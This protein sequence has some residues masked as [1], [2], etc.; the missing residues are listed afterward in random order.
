MRDQIWIDHKQFEELADR[1]ENDLNGDV[2]KVFEDYLARVAEETGKRLHKGMSRKTK[3]KTE[4]KMRSHNRTGR[5]DSAI[6]NKG[7]QKWSGDFVTMDVG[8]NLLDGGIASIFLLYGTPKMEPDK[9]LY[10]AIFGAWAKRMQTKLGKEAFEKAM[11]R[12]LKK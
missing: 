3:H 2:K 12:L 10:N 5:T 7:V 9:F 4:P 8:Y 1:L 11:A 6:I